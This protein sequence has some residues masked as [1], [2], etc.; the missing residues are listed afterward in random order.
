M[1][2]GEGSDDISFSMVDRRVVLNGRSLLLAAASPLV[3][4]YPAV[5][6]HR[7]Q[8]P[9]GRRPPQQLLPVFSSPNPQTL[10]KVQPQDLS[11]AGEYSTRMLLA[12]RGC[13]NSTEADVI[14]CKLPTCLGLQLAG[15]VSRRRHESEL[16]LVAA[17]SREH[18][19][20]GSGQALC[21]GQL[22]PKV[23]IYL[24]CE[25][26]AREVLFAKNK[27]GREVLKS[28]GAQK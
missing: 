11:L 17:V 4:P 14:G 10:H 1:I 9:L 26:N 13:N 2:D 24:S 21:G 22:L 16:P 19:S 8:T 27:K 28:Y 12:A 5:A 25:K 15:S 23:P 6:G 7:F 18:A 20:R 3:L